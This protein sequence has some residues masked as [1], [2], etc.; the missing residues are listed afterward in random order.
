FP[1]STGASASPTPAPAGDLPVKVFRAPLSA[2]MQTAIS[3]LLGHK[4]EP[5]MSDIRAR[6]AGKGPDFAAV[7]FDGETPVAH[8]WIGLDVSDPTVG[9]L[10]HVFTAPTHR[11]RGL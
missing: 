7:A 3:S 11:G 5:W 6:Y 10:G 1:M 4:G 2:A 8:V 9:V